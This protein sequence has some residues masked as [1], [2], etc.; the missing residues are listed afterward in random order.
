MQ[1]Q[2]Q[3]LM[4]ND[5]P[6]GGP[7]FITLGERR[8]YMRDNGVKLGQPLLTRDKPTRSFWEDIISD[9]TFD[10]FKTEVISSMMNFDPQAPDPF[11]E[12]PSLI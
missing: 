2:T 1:E 6:M 11:T 10:R 9:G 8:K 5:K 12:L 4:D 3:G 7:N